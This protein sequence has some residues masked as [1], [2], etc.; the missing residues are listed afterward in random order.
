MKYVL[1]LLITLFL[2]NVSY[3]E[4]KESMCLSYVAITGNIKK[5]HE[6]QPC[7]DASDLGI[8]SAQ[9]SVGMSYGYAGKN[10]LEERYYR[11]A[12]SNRNIAAY[13]SLGHLLRENSPW[14]AI[15]W[16][17]RF[18]ATKAD[19]YGYAAILI[20]NLFSELG[21]ASQA[22]YWLEVCKVSPYNGCTNAYNKKL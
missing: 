13:L 18:A 20:S 14:K 12:A 4:T 15:Y 17:Q 6:Y 21:D 7:L 2:P 10:D 11:L 19:G 5:A 16:Y 9:Y 1:I 3:G 22:E 8:G